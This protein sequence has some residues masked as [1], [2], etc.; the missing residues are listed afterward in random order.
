MPWIAL[1]LASALGC[2]ESHSGKPGGSAG[3]AAESGGR[4]GAAGRAGAGG[5]SASKPTETTFVV[6]NDGK[7][8]LM[9]GSSCGAVWP[10]LF[11]QDNELGLVNSCSCSCADTSV[12]GC[13]AICLNTQELVVPGKSVSKTWEGVALDYSTDRNRSC[14]V[15][16]VPARGAKLKAKACWNYGDQGKAE[17]CSEESFAYGTDTTVT[18]TAK[19]QASASILTKV[20]LVNTTD[21]PI[22]VVKERCGTQGLFDLD[23]GEEISVN[24]FCPCSCDAELKPT[25]CPT[26]GGCPEDV[27]EALAPGEMLVFEWDSGFYYQYESG[28]AGRYT[29]PPRSQVKLE[30]CWSKSPTTAQTCQ[31]SY[32]VI[33]QET[34]LSA[35]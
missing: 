1:L 16:R 33:G 4:A 27:F 2:G 13:P 10:S 34:V 28:C 11:E 9:L 12:C 25:S 22:Y 17:K 29:M 7:D 15:E 6:R 20:G 32:V 5:M 23:M 19:P 14:F 35:F 26:C 31:S 21:A 8:A 24:A 3:A 18:I 30:Q